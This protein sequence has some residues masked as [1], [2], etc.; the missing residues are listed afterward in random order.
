VFS[1]AAQDFPAVSWQR[2]YDFPTQQPVLNI[3]DVRCKLLS[4][5]GDPNF[6]IPLP[7]S[8]FVDADDWIT[9]PYDF[10]SAAPV[11][12]FPSGQAIYL[13]TADDL[14]EA[15]S[16]IHVVYSTPFN[17]DDSWD[18]DTDLIADC[19][20]QEF[21]LD[22]P[23]LGVAGRLLRSAE[24]RRVQTAVQ[25]QS[26][27][28]QQVPALAIIQAADDYERR[29]KDR[30]NDCEMILRGLTPIRVSTT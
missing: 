21:M 5:F 14:P 10:D 4:S 17:V 3:L 15:P 22:I 23:A 24:V 7:P 16:T 19:G 27:D 26:R 11:S 28:A 2:G 30:K 18:E 13:A 20:L 25:G 29:A 12:D 1:V 8:T 9:V 6:P